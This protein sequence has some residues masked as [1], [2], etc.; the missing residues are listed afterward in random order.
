MNF[1][2]ILVFIFSGFGRGILYG[3]DGGDFVVL[4]VRK[5]FQCTGKVE[6]GGN[7]L[8]VMNGLRE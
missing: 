6:A 1:R 3:D 2:I 7:G 4:F 5:K 8:E